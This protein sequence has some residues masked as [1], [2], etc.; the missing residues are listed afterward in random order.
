MPQFSGP[1]PWLEGS[2]W[3]GGLG[4]TGL[5]ELRTW[6]FSAPLS[7]PAWGVVVRTISSKCLYHLTPPLGL[8]ACKCLPFWVPCWQ[9]LVGPAREALGM[10]AAFLGAGQGGQDEGSTVRQ[11][12]QGEDPGANSPP[13]AL[14][15]KPPLVLSRPCILPTPHA[16]ESRLFPSLRADCLAHDTSSPRRLGLWLPAGLSDLE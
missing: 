7:S 8:N 14:A 6:G 11:P 15:K 16:M 10:A 1:L 2:D 4:F 3:G 12:Q 9:G 13:R 5:W